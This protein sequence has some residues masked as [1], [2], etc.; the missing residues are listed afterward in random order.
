MNLRLINILFGILSL[1]IFGTLEAQNVIT[2]SDVKSIPRNEIFKI[3]AGTK[4]IFESGALLRIEGGIEISGTQKSPVIFESK[5]SSN[6]GFGVEIIGFNPNENVLI[7]NAEFKSLLQP[8]R[9]E[10][11]WYRKSVGFENITISKSSSTEP[12]MY[13]ANP[14]LDLSDNKNQINFDINGLILMNNKSGVIL[15]SF[16]SEG[17]LYN[18][19]NLYFVDNYLNGI[20]QSFGILNLIFEQNA[21]SENSKIGRV[22]LL[23]N[24][25]NN[26]PIGVS[27]SGNSNQFV[28]ISNLYVPNAER[29]VFDQRNDYRLPR[30]NAKISNELLPN[31]IDKV[32]LT[33]QHSFGLVKATTRGN[34]KFVK[35]LDSLNRDIDFSF[36]SNRDTQFYFY[37]QGNPTTGLTSEGNL[38]ALPILNNKELSNVFI[39][40]I[41]TAL[42]F[43]Y[44]RKKDSDKEFLSKQMVV[45]KK[46]TLPVFKHKNEILELLKTYEVGFW[47]GGSIYGGGDIKYK[48]AQDYKTAPAKFKKMWLVKDF[49]VFSS[50]EYSRGAYVQYNANSRFAARING[51]YS[52]ISVHNVYAPALF[53]GAR[54]P[55][56]FDDNYNPIK[57]T[58]TTWATHFF[59]KMYILDAEGIW[60]LRSNTIKPFKRSTLVPSLGLSIGLNYFNPY[61]FSN[62]NLDGVSKL[63]Q[64][65]SENYFEYKQR[66]YNEYM[67][68]LRDVGSEGQ[69]FLPG[70]KM[71]SPIALNLGASFNLT[72]K[73]RKWSIKGE[74]KGVY[75]STDYL[76]D[77]GPGLWYG[78]DI[79][80]LNDNMRLPD[81]YKTS[82]IKTTKANPN[83]AANAHRSVDG[84]NDWYYQFHMGVSYNLFG[85]NTQVKKI[86]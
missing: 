3:P 85:M 82:E 75:T 18:L 79:S 48:T 86:K 51:Y 62:R 11:F 72:Y 33:V 26:T 39:S 14:T 35:F 22:F 58:K 55:V 80:K 6:P 78:G 37:I 13:V 32:I 50:I 36:K 23:R 71:Y 49:P 17:L 53:A 63:R 56:S 66:L 30:V 20:D 34:I 54:N 65:K 25:V 29:L 46:L 76:D 74:I 44:L 67:Y 42:Y 28:G 15:E 59:T 70:A 83:V 1:S 43:E 16:N 10:P 68:S 77:F 31:D 45:E 19:D 27:V 52:A 84:L 8:I 64:G 57:V 24:F 38:I 61:R 40:K 41:D 12:V 47:G 2:I 81:I 7:E 60:H 5:D 4:V 69:F 73:R 21:I 9:F